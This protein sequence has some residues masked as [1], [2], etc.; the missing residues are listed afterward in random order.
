MILPELN[1]CGPPEAYVLSRYQPDLA[2]ILCHPSLLS[3]LHAGCG[4]A[5]I[6]I[7]TDV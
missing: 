6:N 1:E 7:K 5:S 2:D 4:V 3:S